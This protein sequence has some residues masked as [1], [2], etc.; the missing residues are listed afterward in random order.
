MYMIEQC[1]S[2]ASINMALGAVFDKV[3]V[4]AAIQKDFKRLERWANRK[5][6]KLNKGK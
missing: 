1:A 6:M 5:D 4:C 3:E 2:S